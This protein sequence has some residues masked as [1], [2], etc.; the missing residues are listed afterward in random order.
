MTGPLAGVQNL[1]KTFGDLRA[2][3]DVS[4][5]IRRGETLAI[6]GETGSGKTTLLR[7]LTRLTDVTEGRVFF[8][9]TD[10]T[11]A[12][13][14]ELRPIRRRM[15]IVFQDPLGSLNPRHS[16]GATIAEPLAIHDVVRGEA[17]TKRVHELM[18]I[19]GLDPT[20]APRYPAEFSGGQLQRVG[21]AR[22][23]ALNPELVVC[24][25]PVSALDVSIRAQILNL[26]AEVKERFGMAFLFISHDLAV[27]RHVADRIG[28]MSQGKL[29]EL[30]AADDVL[31]T[32]KHAYT[33]SLLEA[34]RAVMLNP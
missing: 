3:D 26:L 31:R 6:V 11:R 4:F 2:V 28:V 19:V 13:P 20:L 22:A 18:E 14:A 1:T 9:G 34:A 27:V 7:C 10:I 5:E 8:D 30:G 29:V 12:S 32:P 25:E 33:R 24:D 23:I 15:Q 16:I 17:R 21:I